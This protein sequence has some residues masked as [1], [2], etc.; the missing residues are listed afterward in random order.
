[1]TLVT[2]FYKCLKF[3]TYLTVISIFRL[4]LQN[5]I[6]K[7]SEHC[8]IKNPEELETVSVSIFIIVI[9]AFKSWL[10]VV[11]AYSCAR[12]CSG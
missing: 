10:N 7:L 9:Y 11:L 4:K 8:D 3:T 5:I 6:Q 12:M 2:P 1:M